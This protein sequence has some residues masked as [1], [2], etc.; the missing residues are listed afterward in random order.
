MLWKRILSNACSLLKHHPKWYLLYGDYY[1]LMR[2][3]QKWNLKKRNR[4][5]LQ[6]NYLCALCGEVEQT[7][8]HLFLQCKF[9]FKVWME[10]CKWEVLELLTR[11]FGLARKPRGA[12]I[13]VKNILRIFGGFDLYCDRVFGFSQKGSPREILCVNYSFLYLCCAYCSTRHGECNSMAREGHLNIYSGSTV[14]WWRGR[15][16]GISDGG[17]ASDGLGNMATQK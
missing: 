5:T 16:V 1:Y 12:T 6:D 9:A 11:I 3:K 2:Y 8:I 4:Q 7:S 10:E 13:L 17:L 14:E 15:E